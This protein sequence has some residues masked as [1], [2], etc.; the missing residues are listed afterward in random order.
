MACY[1]HCNQHGCLS[2]NAKIQVYEAVVNFVG[3]LNMYLNKEFYIYN[4]Q[5]LLDLVT[6]MYI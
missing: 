4:L 3:S 2:F 1:G 6:Y 5:L